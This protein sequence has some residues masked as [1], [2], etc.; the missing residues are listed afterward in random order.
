MAL[1]NALFTGLSGLSVNQTKLNVV[2]NNIANANTVAFKGSRAL[3]KPQFYVTDSGGTQPTGDF[4]GTNPSQR[5]LGATVASIEKNFTPGSIEATGRGTDMAIDGDGFFVVRSDSVRYTRDGSFK[6]NANNQL[7]T[8]GGEFVQGYGVDDTFNVVQG[9]LTNMTIPLGAATVATPTTMARFV[10]NLNASGPVASGASIL[11]TQ[12]LTTV[13]GAAAPTA[14]TL[15]TDIASASAPAAALFA[16]GDELTLAA[17]KGGRELGVETFTVTAASTLDDLRAFFEQAMGINTTVTATPAP[18]VTLQPDAGDP[19]AVQLNIVGNLGAA[20]E[21]VLGPGTFYN[22]NNTFPFAFS[23]STLGAA[24]DGAVGEGV[25]TTMVAYDS[26]GTP[27]NVQVTAVLE[28]T[29]TTG[30]TWRFYAESS[31]DSDLDTVVGT[32]T[33]TFDNRGRLRD[34]TGT[35]ITIDRNGAGPTTPL[36]FTLD[37][38]RLTSLTDSESTLVMANQDGSGIGTLTDFT[39]GEDGVITGAFSNGALRTLGQVAVATFSNPQ[40]LIDQGGNL[41]IEGPGSGSAVITTPTALGAGKLVAGA[42]EL[43]NVDL[44]EEFINMIIASTGFTA[45]SRVI[46]TSDQLITE[47]LNTSR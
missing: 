28:Q 36:T 29:A 9:E 14:A 3:F 32:G 39:V 7:V 15:L 41:F 38:S 31:T 42:L 40:G 13:G 27:I 10:G 5:G 34:S 47:L 43:S 12:S 33:L 6:L 2:G 46:S 23:P 30:N 26:L 19:N 45:A 1:S 11:A 44:S 4:G 16:A 25:R 22:Q 20:N 24:A 21:I 8:T 18:G 17:E 37:F 35:T